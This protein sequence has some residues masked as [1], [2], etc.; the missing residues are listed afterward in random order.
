MKL[1]EA[2]ILG[3]VQGLTEFLPV[4]SSGHLVFFQ[5]LFGVKDSVV[6][7]DVAVHWGTALA[8]LIYFGQDFIRLIQQTILFFLSRFRKSGFR[9]GFETYPY[10]RV[11]FLIIVACVPTALIGFGFRE[12]LE[13]L[14][15][16]VWVVALAWAFIG[17]LLLASRRFERGGREIFRM[18]QKDALA[19][20]IAQGIAI[21]PGISR[22]GMTIVAGMAF[23]LHRSEAARFSFLLAIPAILGAGLF[24]MD[25]G[26]AL[27]HKAPLVLTAGFLASA[28]S[29]YLSIALLMKVVRHHAFYRF[30]YYCLAMSAL[31]AGLLFFGKI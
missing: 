5:H 25:E 18:N 4:S 27:F 16:K 28:I 1:I 26:I 29:G 17:M 31:A 30:G 13:S 19:I 11:S 2:V 7:F 9:P 10:A 22:S 15:E 8:V 20:G 21:I 24:K 23:G 14:F 3:V 12:L 6:A